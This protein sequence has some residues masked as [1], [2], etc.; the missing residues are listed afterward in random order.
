V[1]AKGCRLYWPIAST[2]VINATSSLNK[3]STCRLGSMVVVKGR[4][5]PHTEQCCGS[6]SAII[7][8]SWIRIRIISGK[9]DPDQSEKVDALEGHF[10]ALDGPDLEKV[11]GRFRI[12]IKMKGRIRIQIR[13]RVRGEIRILIKVKSR[14]QIRIKVMRNRNTDPEY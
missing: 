10:G 2:E 4:G 13:I 12:R 3:I 5:V 7:L 1:V 11:S 8:G 6:G 14:I 9:L